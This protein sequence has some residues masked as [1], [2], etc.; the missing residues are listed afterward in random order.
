MQTIY[1]RNNDLYKSFVVYVANELKRDLV[2]FFG[3]GISFD[4][5]SNLPLANYLSDPLISALWKAS[6]LALKDIK[7]QS[8][9]M[10]LAEKVF[11]RVRLER[12]LD[13]LHTT[14]GQLALTWHVVKI[15]RKYASL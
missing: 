7:P 12:L 15:V 6:T 2:P 4:R 13:A 11:E 10:Q 1:V 8:D 3:A 5:P 9:E 14:H